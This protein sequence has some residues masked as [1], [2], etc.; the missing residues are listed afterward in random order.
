MSDNTANTTPRP[1]SHSLSLRLS[2]KL[3]LLTMAVIGGVF[4][5]CWFSIKML[6]V[7]RAEEQVAARSLLISDLIALE[8]R[9]GGEAAVLARL[10]SDASMR[11]GALLEVQRGD[12]RVFYADPPKT[13]SAHTR[14]QSFE[15]AL[16][17]IDG[18]LLRATYRE[19]FEADARMGTAWAWILTGRLRQLVP[20]PPAVAAHRDAGPADPGHFRQQAQPAPGLG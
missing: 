8:A 18:G 19:D 16:P 3:A 5:V 9:S 12:G 14:V 11:M 4:I 20:C 10:K 6:L 7:E 17:Q 2:R 13:L 15:L 1:C